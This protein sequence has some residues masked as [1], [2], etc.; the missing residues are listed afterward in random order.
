[1]SRGKLAHPSPYGIVHPGLL[2]KCGIDFEESVVGRLALRVEDHLDDAEPFIHRVEQAVIERLT[3][4]Q[5][6]LGPLA[7]CDVLRSAAQPDRGSGS[8]ADYIK[9]IAEVPHG[10]DG[11][12]GP[13]FKFEWVAKIRDTIPLTCQD[14]A[15]LGVNHLEKLLEGRR[16]T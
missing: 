7:L 3:L 11:W 16:G 1:M 13:A 5:L 12:I 14:F 6:F 9:G 15:I 10:T 2:F 8:I 4:P